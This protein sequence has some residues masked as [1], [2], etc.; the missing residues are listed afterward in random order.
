MNYLT[1]QSTAVTADELRVTRGGREVLHGLS[2]E[3]GAGMITGLLGP[4]G[5]GKST[6][7]RAIVGVQAGVKGDL[8]V[9]GR[10]AGSPEL[11]RRIGYVT[12]SPS[13]YADLTVE[14]NLRYFAAIVDAG[15]QRVQDV[16]E[17][18]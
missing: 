17:A 3:I 18:V 2:F 10:P 5:G 12:Q 11:R 8:E 16:I 6:L 4:S 9:L 15:A 7:L 1:R 14:R 13:V